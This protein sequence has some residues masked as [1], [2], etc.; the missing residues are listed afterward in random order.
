MTSSDVIEIT[1]QELY[2][3]V[4]TT[5]MRTLAGEW[6]LSDVGLAKLCEKHQIPRPAQGH[7]MRKRHGKRVRRTPLHAIDDDRLNTITIS[8]VER[9]AG[10]NIADSQIAQLIQQESEPERAISVSEHTQIRHPFVRATK[11]A[12]KGRRP[13]DYGRVSPNWQYSGSHFDVQVSP[14]N[15]SRALRILQCLTSALEARGYKLRVDGRDSRHP[16]FAVLGEQFQVA[17]RESSKRSDRQQDD[18][19][20]DRW[21]SHRYEY[22]PT[23]VLELCINY[24]TYSSDARL[25]DT[26]RKPLEGRLNEAIIAMLRTVDR[27]R[28]RAELDRIE[29]TKKAE[30]KRIAVEQEI[31]RRSDSARIERLKQLAQAWGIHRRLSDF[32]AA[33]RAEAE[34]RAPAIDPGTVDWLTW[35][36]AY[37][38]EIDPLC[39]GEDLPLYSLT[40]EEHEQLRREC[41][42]DWNQWS[43]TFQHRPAQVAWRPPGQPR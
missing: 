43:E 35:A 26:I 5:P 9:D 38:R 3:R 30:R 28:Q 40:E 8:P 15:V 34:S 14:Q 21:F 12:L 29:A 27:R 19:K 20:R 16:H 4:W 10:P 33:V 25:R 32:V 18:S 36:D 11:E 2:E 22:K 1:R 37:L 7:W 17:V 13:D 42:A 39:G 24:G 23:G 31:G 6:G 41:E